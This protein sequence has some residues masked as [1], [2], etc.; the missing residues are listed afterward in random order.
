VIADH[1]S[2]W[3]VW[4]GVGASVVALAPAGAR[5]LRVAQREH[6]LPGSVSRFAGRWWR[7]EPGNVALAVAAVAGLVL[8]VH[9][10]V[11]AVVPAVVV[12]L[13]PLRLSVRGR[14]SPLALTRR[15]R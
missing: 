10:P 11:V 2:A 1:G 14:T 7:S 8:S 13:G 3:T 6:Y 4:V 12:V 9:W 15:L 5:W